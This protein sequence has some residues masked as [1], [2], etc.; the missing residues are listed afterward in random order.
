M[1]QRTALALCVF[2]LTLLGAGA[3]AR[4]QGGGETK[5]ST[6]DYIDIEQ[7]YVWP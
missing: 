6:Q 7:L 3:Q 1:S 2:S 5:L 4:A